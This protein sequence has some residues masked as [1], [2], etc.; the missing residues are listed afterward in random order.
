MLM[1]MLR[2]ISHCYQYAREGV[3]VVVAHSEEW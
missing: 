3:G 2:R 1:V